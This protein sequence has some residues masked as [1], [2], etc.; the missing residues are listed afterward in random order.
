MKQRFVIGTRQHGR[1]VTSEAVIHIH[2]LGCVS[3]TGVG[4]ALGSFKPVSRDWP[5]DTSVQTRS[6][7]LPFCQELK[8]LFTGA[9]ARLKVP[10]SHGNCS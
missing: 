10:V 5:G 7:P 8:I 1:T 3:K 2:P 9:S 6:R 4:M